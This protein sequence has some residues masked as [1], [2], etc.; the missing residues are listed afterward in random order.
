MDPINVSDI[1][2][3]VH[4][5]R[6]LVLLQLRPDRFSQGIWTRAGRQNPDIPVMFIS[7]TNLTD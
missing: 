3:T 6:E 4:R 2:V 5:V 7:D 1:T